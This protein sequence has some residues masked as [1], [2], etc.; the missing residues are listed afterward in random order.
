MTI[1]ERTNL[2]MEYETGEITDANVL[3]LFANLI[4]TGLAWTLQGSYGR[5]AERFIEDEWI[6]KDGKITEKD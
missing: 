2:I 5:A 3:K 1:D 4:K 6:T